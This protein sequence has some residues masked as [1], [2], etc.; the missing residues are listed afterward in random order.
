MSGSSSGTDGTSTAIDGGVFA[1][2]QANVG[3][4]FVVELVETFAQE[5]PTLIDAMRAALTTGDLNAFRR[6]AHALKSNSNAF[7]ATQLSEL[8]RGL[9]L[10]SM[11]A[12]PG[13]VDALERE[14]ERTLAALRE[15]AHG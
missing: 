10:G 1:E 4:D 14:F 2:L 12:E 3:A 6:T 9:E 8:S 7:G 11:P 13:S 15:L 5:A